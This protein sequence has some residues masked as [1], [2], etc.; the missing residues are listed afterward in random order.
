MDRK[1]GPVPEK[2]EM[3]SSVQKMRGNHGKTRQP[4]MAGNRA[5][6]QNKNLY[7]KGDLYGLAL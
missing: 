6:I 4:Q 1:K 7:R 5:D 3:A 2:Q